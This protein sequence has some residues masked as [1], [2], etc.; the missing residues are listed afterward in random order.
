MGLHRTTRRSVLRTVATG[1]AIGALGNASARQAGPD[2]PGRYIVG[3]ANE[4][5]AGKA[6]RM[7]EEVHR[8][9]DFGDI[10]KAV[11]GRFPEQARE[12]LEKNPNIDYVE[13]DGRMQAIET[14]P[15]GVDHVDAD[16]AHADGYTGSGGDIAILDTGIDSDH[17]DLEANLGAGKAYVDSTTGSEPWDD[18]NS[19]GTHCAGIA[20]AVDNSEGVVGVSTAATLHAVKVL[21]SDG[22][23]Y[24][25]DIAAGLEW[26][27]NQ[28][29][30]VASLSLGGTS[31]SSTIRNACQYAVDNG[32]LVVAAAG[33]DGTADSVRY[34]AKYSSVIAVSATTSSD[35]L[36]Y[37][38]SYGPEVELA[39]PGYS[40]Y[41]TVPGGYGYKSGTSMACPHVAGAGGQL[42]AAGL[43][44][45]EARQTLQDTAE[46]IGLSENKQGYG[47][48]DVGTAVDSLG[49]TDPAIAV[50]TDG[51]SG[52]GTDTAT[53]NGTLDDLGGAS[54]ADVY[55]EYGESGSGLPNTTATQTLSSAGSFSADVSGL[56]AGTDYDYR[57]VADAS[58]GDSDAGTTTGFTTDTADTSVAVSTDS[59][60]SVG[61]TTATLTGTLDSLGGASSADVSF[62]YRQVGASSWTTTA[63][64]TVSSAGSFSADVSNLSSGTD[65]EFRAVADATDGDSDTGTTVGFTTDSADTPVVVSTDGASGVGTDTATLNGTL[66]DLGGASSA[67]VCFEYR[68]SGASSWTTTTVQTLSSTG[69]FSADASGLASGTDYEFRSA[70]DASDGD[71]DTGSQNSF[72]TDSSST[73]TA[74]TV[75]SYRVTEAGSPNPHAEITADWAVSDAEGNLDDVL[76]EVLDG[77]RTVDSARTNVS[78]G[79]ASGSESFKIKHARGA[80]YEVTLTVTDTAGLTGSAKDTVTE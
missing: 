41:A 80:S 68:E 10:G 63:T 54:S 25:S 51:A 58:D 46:D 74:P 8:E 27:A 48:L 72:T 6:K 64:Q 37:F 75:D 26:T 16:L 62:E 55:F 53:L 33:N 61:T 78:G 69:S 42:M 20:D 34:P 35:D 9:L 32:V 44:N 38:S 79:S 5:A 24:Y 60:S 77:G 43:S 40:I 21:A 13:P 36:A 47:L 1:G 22:Y 7:A 45:T 12:A 23:G 15:W 73:N 50:S 66:D 17:P 31:G 49:S 76:V 14:L 59:A 11:A 65:Y 2:D 70:A 67:D 39:A 57:A 28:G 30:D 4:R 19:H 56:S 18:D 3:T 29:Y 52:V 71:T